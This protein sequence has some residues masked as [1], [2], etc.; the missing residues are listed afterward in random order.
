MLMKTLS[1]TNSSENINMKKT[2]DVKPAK[3]VFELLS[4]YQNYFPKFLM[5]LIKK[6]RRCLFRNLVPMSVSWFS[7]GM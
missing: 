3:E 6:R 4:K 1:I 2:I 7:V 5:L